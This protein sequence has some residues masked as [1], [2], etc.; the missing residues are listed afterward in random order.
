M[1]YVWRVMFEGKETPFTLHLTQE[2][3]GDA[4]TM[5]RL[6]LAAR[7]YGFT[8]Q[9]VWPEEEVDPMEQRGL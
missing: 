9:P 4:E 6:V 8:L 5:R 2:H 7:R 3:G 1:K